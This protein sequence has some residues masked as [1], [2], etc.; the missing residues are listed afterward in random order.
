M[1]SILETNKINFFKKSKKI[2]DVTK[3]IPYG[4]KIGSD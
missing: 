1:Y 4:S 3:K 2:F